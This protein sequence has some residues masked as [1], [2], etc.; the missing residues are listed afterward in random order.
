M[1]PEQ[2]RAAR[3]YFD[4]SRDELAKEARVGRNTVARFEAGVSINE[5]TRIALE[6]YFNRI[7]VQFPNN[8]TI[9]FPTVQ[10]GAVSTQ[11]GKHAD[12]ESK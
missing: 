11:K 6:A 4:L 2:C 1:T 5:S 9:I 12:Q 3:T 7:G 8:H 10:D